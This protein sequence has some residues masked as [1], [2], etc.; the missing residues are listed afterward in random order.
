ME[1]IKRIDDLNRE[2]YRFWVNDDIIILDHYTLESRENTR[3]RKYKN[4]K[5]YSRLTSRD[6]NMSV[7]EVPFSEELK[8]EVLEQY[9]K[10]L[11][12]MTWEEYKNK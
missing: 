9:S 3:K 1:I 2:V 8:Q 11:K 5:L 12:V 10:T 6:S 4:I 7:K